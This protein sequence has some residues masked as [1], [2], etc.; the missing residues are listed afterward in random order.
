VQAQPQAQPGATPA[1]STQPT[2]GGAPVQGAG[3]PYS[4]YKARLKVWEKEA[5]EIAEGQAKTKLA[6]PQYQAT[7]DQLLRTADDVVNHKGFETNVGVK[8]ITGLLQLPGTEAR[9][10]QSKYKQLTGETFLSAFNSL[11]GAGAISDKEGAAATEA[12]AALQ[13]PGISEE[14]FRRNVKILQDTVKRGVNRQRM[15]AGKEPDPKYFLGDDAKKNKQAY[16]WAKAHPNDPDTP[17]VLAK[18]GIG[19]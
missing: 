3:E 1:V 11:K 17:A 13:D 15:L 4:V 5:N 9:N 8:G 12:Q 16:E 7:A 10:W 18:L 6:L 14:E 19:E 2:A